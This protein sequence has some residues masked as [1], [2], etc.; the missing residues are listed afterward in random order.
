[1][2]SEAEANLES[3]VFPDDVMNVKMFAERLFQKGRAQPR[4]F[5]GLNCA[6]A[7]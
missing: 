7:M 5:T 2:F 6:I 1:M 3:N 4:L